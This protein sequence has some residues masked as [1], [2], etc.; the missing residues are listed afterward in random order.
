MVLRDELET[1][2]KLL[3]RQGVIAGWHD[4]RIL[5]GEKWEKAI[6]ANLEGADIVLLLV[7]ADFIAS[8]YCYEKDE[9]DDG[10]A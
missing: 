2:L 6:D 10:T 9:A 4:R 1:H 7:S 3:Q 5:P 8:D